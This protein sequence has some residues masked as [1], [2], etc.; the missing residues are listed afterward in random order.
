MRDKTMSLFESNLCI[1]CGLCESITNGKIKMASKPDGFIKP[2]IKSPVGNDEFRLI[3]S[4]CPAEVIHKDDSLRANST[5]PFWGDYFQCHIG[6]SSSDEIEKKASSGGVVSTTLIYLLKNKIIDYVIHIG[7]DESNPLLNKVKL[8][9]NANEVLYNA[10]SRYAPSSPLENILQL[11]EPHK[12]YAF[13]GKPCDVASLR[14]LSDFN[15]QVKNGV[16]YYLSFFCFGVPSLNQTQKLINQLGAEKKIQSLFYR[17]EGWPGSFSI[18]TES[19]EQ[20]SIPYK[21]YMHFLFSDL[22]I[23]CKICPDGLGESADITC[24]DAWNEFDEKGYPSFKNSRG[25]SIIF[26]K[27]KN[28]DELLTQMINSGEIKIDNKVSDLRTIDKVQPGQ[29]GKKKFHKFRIWAFR[30][31]FKKTPLFDKY[32]YK[33][34]HTLEKVDLKTALYQIW[35]TWKRIN[36]M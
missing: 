15:L 17:K 21:D 27:T 7:P 11:I 1:G 20:Y 19:G 32:I 24:G 34:I 31:S 22:H 14:R 33:D 16:L 23:R 8:S 10:D 6:S 35:G 9:S 13:V 30:L 26:S 2:S 36:L 28:G 3:Q 18:K 12:K 29:F 5:D 25:S 4:C